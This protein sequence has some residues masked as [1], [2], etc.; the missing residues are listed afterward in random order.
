[1]NRGFSQIVSSNRWVVVGSAAFS[2]SHDVEA[3]VHG[4]DR[5]GGTDD[6]SCGTPG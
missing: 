2:V 6:R 5:V 3:Q 1:M 4:G